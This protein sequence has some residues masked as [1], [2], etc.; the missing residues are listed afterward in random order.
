MKRFDHRGPSFC[1]SILL[2]G[3]A[4]SVPLASCAALPF[5]VPPALDFARNLLATSGQ[6]YSQS[7]TD[8][9]ETLL[10][11]LAAPHF[12]A[13]GYPQGP[14][15]AVLA[16]QAPAPTTATFPP[17]PV[18]DP[19]STYPGLPALAGAVSPSHPG[20]SPS[21][22]SDGGHA[23]TAYTPTPGHP[24]DRPAELPR[25]TPIGLEIALLRQEIRNGEK[26]PVPIRDGD[27]LRDGRGDPKIGDKFRIVFRP[28]SH[29]YV[30]VI[31]VDGSGWAQGLFPSPHSSFSN[32]VFQDRLY[33]LPE[34]NNW[35]ALDQFRGIETIYFVA[36]YR[37]R[38]DIEET[39]KA[40]AGRERPTSAVPQQVTE[41]PVIPR[42]FGSIAPGQTTA[43]SSRSGDTRPVSLTAFYSTQP[44]EDLRI[45]RWFRHE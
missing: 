37:Q 19:G 43:I 40:I 15:G 2:L 36:S 4:C 20:P 24:A 14:G 35:Y 42:G 13:G 31:A 41:P 7:Y 22:P 45:T 25:S 27:T 8:R 10:L 11:A 18:P 29:S 1:P 21:N 5:L 30:Y 32:P 44:T 23:G 34:G 38:P 17:A 28:T 26:V 6:N 16:G 39:L 9:L 12:P 3:I 33:V